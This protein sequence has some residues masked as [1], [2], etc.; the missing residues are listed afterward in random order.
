MILGSHRKSLAGRRVA[1]VIV[2]FESGKLGVAAGLRLP[3]AL[4]IEREIHCSMK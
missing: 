4:K 3:I 2:G 1:K